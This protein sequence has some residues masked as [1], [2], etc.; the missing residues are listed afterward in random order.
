MAKKAVWLIGTLG[1]L[2]IAIV[3][4]IGA[5]ANVSQDAT[6]QDLL[7]LLVTEDGESRLDSIE[8]MLADIDH[9]VDLIYTVAG[10]M[11]EDQYGFFEA[12]EWTLTDIKYQLN[13]IEQQLSDIKACLACP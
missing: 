4:L 9:E 13:L 8:A 3:A 12:E 6:I 5:Q 11:L 1:I 2:A 7:D 10:Q